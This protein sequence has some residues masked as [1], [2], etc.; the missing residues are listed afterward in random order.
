MELTVYKF[1]GNRDDCAAVVAKLPS[2]ANLAEARLTLL[3]TSSV[4]DGR[5][6]DVVASGFLDDAAVP[7]FVVEELQLLADSQDPGKRNKGRAG[8]DLLNELKASG[9]V[10]FVARPYRRGTPVDELLVDFAAECGHRI[11]TGDGN[12]SKVAA[13]RGVRALSLY[14]L[15]YALAPKLRV[16]DRIELKIVKLGSN[17]DQG[18][19]YL[20]DGTMVVVDGAARN[21]GQKITA[22]V[23]NVH[24]TSGG[25]MLFATTVAPMEVV[26]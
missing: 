25:R 16:N 20:E 11:L 5:I 4:L 8:L 26:A 18:I 17:P 3:D 12:L 15:A 10:Q 9:G 13:L 7:A 2:A 24:G 22:R 14:E 21:I 1:S 19:G 23:S 6:A